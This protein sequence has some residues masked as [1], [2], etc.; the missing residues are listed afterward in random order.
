MSL[1]FVL[2]GEEYSITG[3]NGNSMEICIPSTYNGLPVTEIDSMAF[4]RSGDNSE[5]YNV[6]FEEPS[7]VRRIG[8]YAFFMCEHLT[9]VLPD[10]ITDIEEGAFASVGRILY[11]GQGIYFKGAPHAGAGDIGSTN[12][13]YPY[14]HSTIWEEALIEGV[15]RG[16]SMLPDTKIET[17]TDTN[18]KTHTSLLEYCIERS[19][20]KRVQPRRR[21]AIHVL[22]RRR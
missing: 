19:G 7:H 4:S 3:Y 11:K 17:A 8:S 9:I 6:T 12:G 13:Y 14:V 2:H 15:Y 5:L 21:Q 1:D 18:T 20:G 22:P 16:L 10:S